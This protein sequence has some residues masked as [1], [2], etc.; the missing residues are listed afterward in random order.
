MPEKPD[1]EDEMLTTEDEEAQAKPSETSNTQTETENK[2]PTPVKAVEAISKVTSDRAAASPPC[3]V[4]S[5][6][7]NNEEKEKEKHSAGSGKEKSQGQE[8]ENQEATPATP[9]ITT[10]IV[11]ETSE[12]VEIEGAD[13][14]LDEE[15]IDDDEDAAEMETPDTH[16]D[17][18]THDKQTNKDITGLIFVMFN[19][20]FLGIN[21]IKF[22]CSRYSHG[23]K[24]PLKHKSFVNEVTLRGKDLFLKFCQSLEQN[25][26]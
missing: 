13:P 19:P 16:P 21:I 24:D 2:D 9:N 3:E 11:A 5:T 17:A 4:S 25:L 20:D 18:D 6:T 10:E 22:I 26:F 8:S 23:R 15:E 14:N 7:L 1:L 12:M